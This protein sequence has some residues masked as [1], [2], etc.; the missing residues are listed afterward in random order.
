MLECV[1]LGYYGFLVTPNSVTVINDHQRFVAYYTLIPKFIGHANDT[2]NHAHNHQPFSSFDSHH[3][4][5]FSLVNYHIV[6]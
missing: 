3:F 2:A 6:D 5:T 4:S 1:C